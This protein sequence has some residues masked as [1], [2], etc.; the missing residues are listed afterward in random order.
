[1]KINVYLGVNDLSKRSQNFPCQG[2]VVSQ[3]TREITEKEAQKKRHRALG[4]NHPQGCSWEGKLFLGLCRI[5]WRL[6]PSKSD[7]LEQR[8]SE[9]RNWGLPP[10]TLGSAKSR[11]GWGHGQSQRLAVLPQKP[12]IRSRQSLPPAQPHVLPP[13]LA[14][15]T[16]QVPAGVWQVTSSKVAFP[17]PLLSLQRPL[18]KA[19]GA[20]A[21][22]WDSAGSLGAL[23]RSLGR[24]RSSGVG[25]LSSTLCSRPQLAGG[26]RKKLSPPSFI[27]LASCVLDV[28]LKG[29][30]K[31]HK[32]P[33]TLLLS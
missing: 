22:S 21:V 28:P 25:G 6:N 14:K 24:S 15:I 2:R 8:G 19:R 3:V 10:C 30:L 9:S 5:I 27:F 17:S 20:G 4:L 33:W 13:K 1:M 32:L 12:K 26:H 16:R 31:Q 23:A 7:T 29:P 11:W 18:S